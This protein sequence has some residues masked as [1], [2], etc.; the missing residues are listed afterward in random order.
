VPVAAAE[1]RKSPPSRRVSLQEGL[2]TRGQQYAR[3][4]RQKK[5]HTKHRGA[6]RVCLSVHGV[7]RRP[8]PASAPAHAPIF[9]Q[10]THNDR[11]A[12]ATEG[13]GAPMPN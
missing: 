8:E 7:K 2:I 10:H 1:A 4:R 12:Q 6:R 11:K 3:V 9:R 13:P 5:A